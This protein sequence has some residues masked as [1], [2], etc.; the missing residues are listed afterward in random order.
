MLLTD[1]LAQD[2]H[3][4]CLQPWFVGFP[5]SLAGQLQIL[6]LLRHHSHMSHFLVINQPLYFSVH[7]YV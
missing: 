3:F 7:T 2:I 6:G 5:G 4:S 1:S